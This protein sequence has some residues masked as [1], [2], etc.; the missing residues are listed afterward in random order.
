MTSPRRSFSRAASAASAHANL[1][2][3]G[4]N[5]LG[6]RRATREVLRRAVRRQPWRYY[7]GLV[8]RG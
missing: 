3:A 5:V 6:W 2:F 8:R 7:L 1:G 4:G